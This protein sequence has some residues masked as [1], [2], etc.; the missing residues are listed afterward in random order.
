MEDHCPICG[1]LFDDKAR[2]GQGRNGSCQCMCKHQS[3]SCGGGGGGGGHIPAKDTIIQITDYATDGGEV[4][5]LG[6]S[7]SGRLYLLEHNLV[8]V[9]DKDTGI[10]R[11]V[12]VPTH[13]K[14]LVESPSL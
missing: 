13:W 14:L 11:Q 12:Y 4:Q 1:C 2:P 3:S 6:L 9:K 5:T 7:K 8:V 10:G